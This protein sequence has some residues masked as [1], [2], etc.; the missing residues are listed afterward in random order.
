M[1]SQSIRGEREISRS[2]SHVVELVKWNDESCVCV[3]D[4]A[5]IRLMLSI[6]WKRKSILAL[7]FL[8]PL[9]AKNSSTIWKSIKISISKQ[10]EKDKAFTKLFFVF[11]GLTDWV[12]YV[13]KFHV[14]IIRA[15]PFIWVSPFSYSISG[16]ANGNWNIHKFKFTM[17]LTKKENQMKMKTRTVSSRNLFDG[18]RHDFL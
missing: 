11:L 5:V 14:S 18:R 2:S 1:E 6:P 3:W 16:K 17:Q 8:F 13:E 12:T 4:P 7:F 9:S 10:T 15:I